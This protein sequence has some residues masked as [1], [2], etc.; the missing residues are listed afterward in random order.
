VGN[1]RIGGNWDFTYRWK[2]GERPRDLRLKR[3]ET[4]SNEGGIS[5]TLKKGETGGEE[6][7]ED[8]KPRP[9]SQSSGSN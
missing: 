2:E 1:R 4:I 9:Y 5:R 7:G 8:G 3:A 6:S